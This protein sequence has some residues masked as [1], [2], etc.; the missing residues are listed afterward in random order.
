MAVQS[1]SRYQ[2]QVLFLLSSLL[3]SSRL[4][5]YVYQLNALN[6]IHFYISWRP[7][8]FLIGDG[9][10]I[11]HTARHIAIHML[12]EMALKPIKTAGEAINH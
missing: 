12:I 3:L 2:C 7:T 11:L 9:I 1:L 8:S 6:S 10:L 5:P 4:D